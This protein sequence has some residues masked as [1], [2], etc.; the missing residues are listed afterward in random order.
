MKISYI[1]LRKKLKEYVDNKKEKKEELQKSK[2]N[3]SID[4]DTKFIGI[5][6]SKK[7]KYLQE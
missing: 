6:Y 7:E 1:S 4:E 5:N 2:E 3:N